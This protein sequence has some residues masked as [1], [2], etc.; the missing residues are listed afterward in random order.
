[1]R[2]DLAKLI[3]D[4][5]GELPLPD[6]RNVRLM[7]FRQFAQSPEIQRETA[8]RAEKIGQAI[9]NLI[10]TNGYK[11]SHPADPKPAEQPGRKVAKAHCAHCGTPVLKIAVDDDMNA[12]LSAQALRAIQQMRPECPHQ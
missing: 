4:N 2:N 7:H 5:L 8:K 3:A 11:I 6:G 12:M 1:M 10:A 9:V